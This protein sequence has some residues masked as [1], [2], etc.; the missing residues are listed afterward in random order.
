M[1][2]SSY[3][4]Y[5]R[6]TAP[7]AMLGDG[8]NKVREIGE[9]S[10]KQRGLR[11]GLFPSSERDPG[12]LSSLF[13]PL[14]RKGDSRKPGNEKREGL[15]AVATSFMFDQQAEIRSRS[16]SLPLSFDQA[17]RGTAY[18]CEHGL[19]SQRHRR[20]PQKNSH[21]ARL[22]Q[23]MKP[24]RGTEW[25]ELRRQVNGSVSSASSSLGTPLLSAV[26]IAPRRRRLE[27]RWNRSC[28]RGSRR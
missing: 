20:I 26:G 25:R 24:G 12:F 11:A 18:S 23:G 3:A 5:L 28:S 16:P 21:A 2:C 17:D 7:L 10:S 14:L 19:P 4:R 6:D 13:P 1:G 9:I 15:V 8:S 27:Q 22:G